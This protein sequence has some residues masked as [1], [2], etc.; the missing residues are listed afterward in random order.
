[1]RDRATVFLRVLEYYQGIVFLTTN[2][3]KQLDIAIPSRI[4][5]AIKYNPLT[6]D[7][8]DAIFR[9]FL[10]PLNKEGKIEDFRSLM[11]WLKE[12][13]YY[14][15]FD[16]RQIRNIVTTALGLARADHAEGKTNKLTKSHMLRAFRNC[17][18]FK[19]EWLLEYNSYM[20]DQK[21]RP[22]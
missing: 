6:D 22:S 7:Q 4:H 13:V 17:K 16:G 11:R 9:G 5:I 10:E 8:M 19:D 2:Q 18:S 1:M 3:I 20:Q 12:D 21:M 14:E 15:K